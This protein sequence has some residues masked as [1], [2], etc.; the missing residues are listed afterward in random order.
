MSDLHKKFNAVEGELN[1]IMFERR[2][3]VHGLT[4]SMLSNT[5]M[6]LLGPPGTGKSLLVTEWSK[7]LNS[8]VYF[9][10]MLSKFSTP[11]E[12]FG[13]YSLSALE[14]DKYKRVTTGKLP[15][16]HF[17]FI[18]EIFK[19]GAAILNSMLTLLNERIFYNDGI[20]VKTPLLTVIGASNEIPESEDGLDALYDR[21][22]LKFNVKPI[23]ETKNFKLMLNSKLKKPIATISLEDVVSAQE[24]IKEVK[25]TSSS[26]DTLTKIRRSI[27]SRNRFF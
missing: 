22:Q 7:R 2:E 14:L 15:E 3:M 10:W 21:F 9:A 26:I 20:P 17:G 5:N 1:L 11:E 8:S 27:D 25:L 19:A 4:L 24:A 12:I 16:A 23:S 6:L 18:D 13:P